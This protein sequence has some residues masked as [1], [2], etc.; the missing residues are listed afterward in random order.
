MSLLSLPKEII[1][2][3]CLSGLEP[4]DVLSLALTS[5][6]LAEAIHNEQE[7]NRGPLYAI[8][9]CNFDAINYYLEKEISTLDELI[10]H[11]LVIDSLESLLYLLSR[12]DLPVTYQIMNREL[13]YH[14]LAE[15]CFNHILEGLLL[16]QVELKNNYP[17]LGQHVVTLGNYRCILSLLRTN[18]YDISAK[19]MQY[20]VDS[21]EEVLEDYYQ[22]LE[23]LTEK[24]TS[25][26]YIKFINDF[27]LTCNSGQALSKD[28]W[29][30]GIIT[31]SQMAYF[32]KRMVKNHC[33]L[34]YQFIEIHYFES[35][36]AIINKFDIRKDIQDRV[37]ILN[38]LFL[39]SVDDLERLYEYHIEAYGESLS[40]IF[41]NISFVNS[42]E[43]PTHL[44]EKPHFYNTPE[45]FTTMVRLCTNS[46]ILEYKNIYRYNSEHIVM[47]NQ[48][49]YHYL[50]TEFETDL[51]PD[52]IG[53][54]KMFS[55]MQ[56]DLF[57]TRL[58]GGTKIRPMVDKLLVFDYY[59]AFDNEPPDVSISYHIS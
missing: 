34:F 11:C 44:R 23:I 42:R 8:Q 56:G 39:Y 51:T 22:I 47:A 24:M 28:E 21:S 10:L 59:S 49:S 2:K 46:N 43:F 12:Y 26:Q 35:Y 29:S 18:Q 20:P 7:Y 55:D 16:S 31:D 48:N 30:R 41:T 5:K 9:K 57:L 14:C 53:Y 38:K 1:T 52:E 4:Q 27:F 25:V 33:N 15:K 13:I 40:H 3:I 19:S 58:E 50:E 45:F 17:N 6:S 54:I 37:T 32:I 36:R